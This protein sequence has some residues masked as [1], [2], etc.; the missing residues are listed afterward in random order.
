[1]GPTNALSHLPDPDT[2]SDNT[3]VTLLPDDLFIH[4]IDM[5]FVS[6]IASS[7]L[8]NPLILD[9]INSLH[10][11]SPLFPHSALTNWKYDIPHLYLKITSTFHLSPAT[12]LSPQSTCLSPLGTEVSSTHTPCCLMTIGGQVCL[13][14]FAA[15]LLVAPF[16]S[17]WRSIPTQPFLLYPL[18]P[19]PAPVPSNSS[20]STESLIFPFPMA[21]IP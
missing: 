13:P 2:S 16:A 7:Y 20:P 18:S 5:A 14:L 1:M 11:G 12:T 9:V 6:K 4:I 10:A 19:P 17:K 21:L 3:N 15:S 8:T